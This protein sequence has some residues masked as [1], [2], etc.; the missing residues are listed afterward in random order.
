V[1]PGALRSLAGGVMYASGLSTLL[2]NGNPLVRFDGY[3]VLADALE[4]PNLDTRSRRYLAWLAQRHLFGIESARSP[5][6]APGEARWL[7]AHGLAAFAYRLVVGLAIALFLAERFFA[8]G[9]GLALVAVATQIGVPLARGLGFVLASPRLAERRARAVAVTLGIAAAVAILLGAVPLPSATR[10]QGVVWPPVGAEVRAGSDGFVVRLLA[11]PGAEVVRGASLVLVREPALD[12]EIAVLDA[13]RRQ[14]EARALA[15]RALDPAR[16]QAARDA[17]A[18]A[19]AALAH[20]RERAGEAVARS[21]AD[22]RFVLRDAASLVGRYVRRGELLGWVIGPV[23]S[24]LRVAVPNADV[25]RIRADTASVEVRTSRALGEALPATIASMTPAASHEL[26]SPALG[27]MGGGPFAV[28]PADAE[29]MR[30]LEP[31]FVLDLALPPGAA[32]P[33]IGG[34]AWVRFDH[35]AEPAAL[36]GWRAL[37]RLLLRR[38]GV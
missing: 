18:T 24:T 3:Y 22:G 28:D 6:T 1:E 11:D 31:V 30:V 25:A 16:A 5:I 13:Q 2:W 29:G 12:A 20:A 4:I 33:E 8:L 34:R 37:R 15:E 10:A 26:P 27:S 17:L 35:R 36:Q 9:I 7:V 38:I 19:E 23:V 21:S 14:A 32:I